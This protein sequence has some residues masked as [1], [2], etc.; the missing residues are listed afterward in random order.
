MSL[1]LCSVCPHGVARIKNIS[2]NTGVQGPVSN[3]RRIVTFLRGAVEQAHAALFYQYKGLKR[4][5]HTAFRSIG[6]RLIETAAHRQVC[7]VQQNSHL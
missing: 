1:S 6:R 2:L 5:H 3:W 7:E 4:L